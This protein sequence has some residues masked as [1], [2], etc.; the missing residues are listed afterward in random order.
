MFAGLFVVMMNEVV[1]HSLNLLQ[2]TISILANSFYLFTDF[3]NFILELAIVIFVLFVIK[4]LYKV[5]IIPLGVLLV[6]VFLIAF[7]IFCLYFLFVFFVCIFHLKSQ[8]MTAPSLNRYFTFISKED[9][10]DR[11]TLNFVNAVSKVGSVR[12]VRLTL[13]HPEDVEG[14]LS[15]KMIRVFPQTVEKRKLRDATD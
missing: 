12:H 13:K 8:S 7:C 5:L 15:V 14:R 4:D 10:F 3:T 1:I 11:S 6:F 2:R 9:F